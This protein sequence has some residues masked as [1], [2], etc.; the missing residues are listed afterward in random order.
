MVNRRPVLET[1][2]PEWTILV[3]LFVGLVVFFAEDVTLL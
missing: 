3:C 2:A 1:R